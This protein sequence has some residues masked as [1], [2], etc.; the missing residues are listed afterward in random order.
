MKHFLFNFVILL[1]IYLIIHN[2]K[3]FSWKRRKTKQ[4]HQRNFSGNKAY[5]EHQLDL[6]LKNPKVPHSD[7]HQHEVGGGGDRGNEWI[8]KLKIHR[9]HRL[10]DD[11]YA[12]THRQRVARW[13]TN[14]GWGDVNSLGSFGSHW[15][16]W[17]E[18]KWHTKQNF[19]T[20]NIQIQL[21]LFMPCQNQLIID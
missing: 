21:T 4:F 6:I 15:P 1:F 13:H 11:S 5:V 8:G 17:P 14:S 12:T 3:Y 18:T 20:I 10:P 2:F 9:L 16:K 7:W 19:K